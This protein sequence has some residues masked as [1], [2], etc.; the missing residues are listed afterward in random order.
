[1]PTFHV[2]D[3]LTGKIVGRLYPSTWTFTDALATTGSGSLTVPLPSDP[4]DVARLVDLTAPRRRWVAC[5][6]EQGRFWFAGPIPRAPGRGD[7]VVTVPL[8]DWRTWFYLAPIRPLASGARQNYVRVG[9]SATE[10]TTMATDLAALA[11][12][13]VGAPKIVLDTA[14]ASGIVRERTCMMLDRSV[15]EYLDGLSSW[16]VERGVEWWTYATRSLADPTI[17]IPHLAVAWPER[18]TRT[19][20]IRVEYRAGVGGNAFDPAWPEGVETTTRAWAVGDGEPPDQVWASDESLDI[21]AGVEVAWEQTIGP[22]DGVKR[23][24]TA[25]EAAFA[26]VQYATGLQGEAEFSLLDSTIGLGDYGTGDRARVVYA[27]GWVDVEVPAA[28]IVERTVS[29]GRGQPTVCRL[30]VD[31]A[32][33]V[34]GDSGLAPGEAVVDDGTA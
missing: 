34:Y 21:A 27:D 26:L 30:K 25:F 18:A 1:M 23:K 11:L 5:E 19:T 10:Q 8:V 32:N 9:A 20:P 22:L 28:R 33:G 6:D 15:G 31:L 13:T 7:G 29:G 4:A 24:A 16:K 3:S 17:L 14:T 2:A 12:A